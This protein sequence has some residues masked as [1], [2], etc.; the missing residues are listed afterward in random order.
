[1]LVHALVIS[2]LDYCNS[3]FNNIAATHLKPL[4]SVL[5]AAAR[6]VVRKRKFD[7]V[8]ED[9]RDYLHWLPVTNRIDYKLCVLVFKSLHQ[10]A[11][12]YLSDMC[13]PASTDTNRSQL[14]SAA[15]GRLLDLTVRR[16]RTT[17]YGPR[18]FAVAGPSI[19]NT[20][21][22]D[23]REPTLTFK[24]FCS[25]LKTIMFNRAYYSRT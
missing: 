17:T 21:P 5:H 9:V 10:M 20:L 25:K 2:R 22:R 23:I 13:S 6:L 16:T 12:A 11:P 15:Q 8:T 7:H 18:S 1:M 19:W 4:Q 14:R 3:V 24:Q